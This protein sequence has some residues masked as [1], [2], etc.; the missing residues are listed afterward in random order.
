MKGLKGKIATPEKLMQ[1]ILNYPK[2]FVAF[3]LFANL[4]ACYAQEATTAKP[5][6]RLYEF[7]ATGFYDGSLQVTGSIQ[8]KKFY[9]VVGISTPTLPSS[10]HAKLFL[11]NSIKNVCAIFDD[12][13]QTCFGTNTT[14]F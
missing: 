9:D 8:A 7:G 11:N 3:M 13:S 14:G 4:S 10:N 5:S 1:N 6:S 2:C 12:A